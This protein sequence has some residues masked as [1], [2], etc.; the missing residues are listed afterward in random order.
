MRSW[1]DLTFV[2][3][4]GA[5]WPLYDR[6]VDWPRFLR[7]LAAD[8]AGARRRAYLRLCVLQWTV[9]A[10]FV[11]G[12]WYLGRDL[13]ALRLVPV[14]G[15]RLV[16][17]LVVLALLGASYVRDIPRIARSPR[18]RERLRRGAQGFGQLAPQTPAEVAWVLPV[19]LTAG[20]TEELLYRGFFPVALAP[21][22][23]WWGGAA[24]SSLC[25]GLVHAYQGRKGIVRAGIVGA[26]MALVVAATGSLLPAMALHALFD[27]GGLLA[28]GI[29]FRD[30]DEPV[31]AAA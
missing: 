7:G 24:V 12:W 22:L 16:A 17:T 29:A 1:F 27:V 15:W 4:L 25:F 11:A 10:V 5:A 8:P 28:V 21:W 19:S 31:A 23:G 26:G 13:G 30:T 20:I 3:L 6:F 18:S 2:A 14:R 9:V